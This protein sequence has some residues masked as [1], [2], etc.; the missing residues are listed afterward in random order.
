MFSNSKSN[1][2][3]ET[4]FE[5]ISDEVYEATAGAYNLKL[6]TPYDVIG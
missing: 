3:I 5:R 1:F 6:I 4:F 2:N